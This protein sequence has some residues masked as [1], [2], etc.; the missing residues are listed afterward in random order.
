MKKHSIYFVLVSVL[1]TACNLTPPNTLTPST[2]TATR[3]LLGT[4]PTLFP[5]DTS[6]PEPTMTPTATVVSTPVIQPNE[7][8]SQIPMMPEGRQDDMS[9][10]LA[11]MLSQ[12]MGQD[13]VVY[14]APT[15]LESVADFYQ[16]RLPAQD[17]VWRYTD[18][19]ESLVM[20]SPMPIL[21][22]EFNQGSQQLS[23]AA[24]ANFG[25][26][27]DTPIAL[28]FAGENI[29]GSE[30]LQHF[31]SLMAG[32]LDLGPPRQQDVQP[33]AMRF[34]SALIKFNHP[35]DWLPTDLQIARLRTDTDGNKAI[36]VLPKP[37]RCPDDD[38]S[39]W[40][41][42]TFVTRSLFDAPI[43]MYVYPDQTDTTLEAFDAQR[44]ANLGELSKSSLDTRTIQ[45]PEDLIAPGSLEM[46]EIRSITLANNTP[47]LQ[48]L[49]NWQQI[50][51]STPLVS[52]YTLF[53]RNDTIIEFHTD[54]TEEEWSRL[55]SRVQETIR[56]IEVV[57]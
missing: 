48:H 50:G 52:S 32:G 41:N 46:I 2:P 10:N 23:I 1:L 51:L 7:T 12:F 26:K 16:T 11:M 45:R 5:P 37:K 4:S 13:I 27:S 14:S 54:F 42:F 20:S 39:C 8:I 19:G 17:W 30:L 35:S 43:M 57:P 53:K 44:W 49:Y 28:V 24:L 18:T 6:T 21:L 38:A 3:P 55:S 31:V 47:A 33:Q 22:Q 25:N 56:S 29:G 34:T 9:A 40:V 36:N 15:S